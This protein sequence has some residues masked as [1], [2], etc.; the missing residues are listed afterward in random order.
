MIGASGN[1]EGLDP[2]LF[3]TL[4]KMAP[5]KEEEIKLKDFNDDISKLGTA[6]RFLKAILDIPFAFRRVEAMLYRANFSSEVKYLR[7]SFQTLEVPP[8]SPFTCYH[9][10]VNEMNYYVKISCKPQFAL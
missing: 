10:S 7:K 1:P 5:S 8:I 3:E 9:H 6:E 2:E 4:V